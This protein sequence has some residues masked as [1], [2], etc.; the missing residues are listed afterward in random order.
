MKT[1]CLFCDNQAKYIMSGYAD[2]GEGGT[3]YIEIPVCES[4]LTDIK[5]RADIEIDVVKDVA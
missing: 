3:E 2:T 5:G 1:T 4:C